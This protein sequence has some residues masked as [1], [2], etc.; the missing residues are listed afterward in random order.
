MHHY[1]QRGGHLHLT[2]VSDQSLRAALEKHL[3]SEWT[4]FLSE[5]DSHRVLMPRS[6]YLWLATW[7]SPSNPHTQA[8]STPPQAPDVA[9]FAPLPKNRSSTQTMEWQFPLSCPPV[10]S[11]RSTNISASSQGI[12]KSCAAIVSIYLGWLSLPGK[13]SFTGSFLWAV[14]P[15]ATEGQCVGRWSDPQKGG[16]GCSCKSWCH[17]WGGCCGPLP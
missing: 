1:K 13:L 4:G 7:K 11:P 8:S 3:Y 5:G 6:G 12:I 9:P 16:W 2:E 15:K 17:Q 14:A 10:C